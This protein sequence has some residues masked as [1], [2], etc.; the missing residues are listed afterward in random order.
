MLPAESRRRRPTLPASKRLLIHHGTG[1]PGNFPA[2][3]PPGFVSRIRATHS[4]VPGRKLDCRRMEPFCLRSRA[5]NSRQ[6]HGP[7]QI[8]CSGSP[9]QPAA[10]QKAPAVLYRSPAATSVPTLRSGRNSGGT[11][12]S[13]PTAIPQARPVEFP[14]RKEPLARKKWSPD[15][16]SGVCET[17]GNGGS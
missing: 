4:G 13:G 7:C 2:V 17:G 11:S 16:S 12:Q 6:S 15:R 10:A 3:L 14:L 8:F 1:Q 5:T 9:S